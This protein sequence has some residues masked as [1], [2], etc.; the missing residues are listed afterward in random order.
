MKKIEFKKRIDTLFI[1]AEELFEDLEDDYVHGFSIYKPVKA[2]HL[3][4]GRMRRQIE[5]KMKKNGVDF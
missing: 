1:E 3:L 5:R 2:L 4:L